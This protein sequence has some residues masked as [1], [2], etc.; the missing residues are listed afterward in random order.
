[1]NAGAFDRS[2]AAQAACRELVRVLLLRGLRVVT[3]ESLTGGLA[4][5]LLVDEPDSGDVMAGSVVAYQTDEKRRVLGV[6]ETCVVSASCASQMAAGAARLFGVPCAV[7][8][9]GVAGPA[10]QESQPVG[11]VFVAVRCGERD[12]VL[13]RHL[14]GEPDD[15]RLAAI[16]AGFEELRRLVERS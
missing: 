10:T 15:I 13:E 12:V 14:D 3:A 1:M 16:A 9:T 7:A 11:T 8:F 2:H 6:N 4:S 5:Y